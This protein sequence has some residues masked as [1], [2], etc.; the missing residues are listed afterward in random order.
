MHPQRFVRRLRHL[1][2]CSHVTLCVLSPVPALAVDPARALSQ[3]RYQSWTSEHGLPADT[4]NASVHARDGYLWLGTEE[5]LARFD[6]LRFTVF[7]SRN[8][9][10]M[11]D[12]RVRA[13]HEDS[14]GTLWV[15]TRGGGL[16]R[17]RDHSF[18]AITT[19]DGLTSDRILAVAGGP[20][21]VV[22]IATDGGGINRYEN[23]RVTAYSTRQGLSSDTV[24]ALAVDGHGVVWA[25]T[26]AGGLDRLAGSRFEHVAARGQSGSTAAIVPS[27]DG[28]IWFGSRT[29]GLWRLQSGQVAV[30]GG[31]DGLAGDRIMSLL[32]DR[33]ANIWVGTDGHGIVRLRNGNGTRYTAADGF[34]GDIAA[35]LSEDREGSIWIGTGG[36]GLVQ[37]RDSRFVSFGRTEGLSH[38]MALAVLA[39]RSGTI[40]IG[41]HGG[42][43]NRLTAGRLSPAGPPALGTAVIYSLLEDSRGDI[44]VGTADAGIVQ[45]RREGA[46]TFHR[47]GSGLASNT[48]HALLEDDRGV[49]WAGTRG[50]VSRFENGRWTTVT[51]AGG[52]ANAFVTALALGRGGV[53]W[54][55][56]NGGGLSRIDGDRIAT[57]TAE[58]HLANRVRAVHEDSN[59]RVWVGTGGGGLNLFRDGRFL[60]LTSANGVPD[61]IRAIVDDGS[62][63]FWMSSNRGV[64]RAARSQLL[65]AA[66]DPDARVDAAQFGVADGMRSAEI[67]GGFQP[68]AARGTDGRIWFPTAR[69]VTAVDP[70]WTPSPA[71]P[72]QVQIESVSL[73]RTPVTPSDPAAR[74][75]GSGELEVTYTGLWFR[76]PSRLRFQY[77][78]QNFDRGWIDAGTRR[79]AFYTNL[80]AGSYTFRVRTVTA[81]DVWSEADATFAVQLQPRFYQT[82]LFVTLCVFGVA[83]ALMGAYR[84]RLR[85]LR[86]LQADLMRLVRERT[87]QLEEAN[88]SLAQM[89]YVDALTE[90]AN[91]RSFEEALTTE[92]RR[93]AR[94]RSNLSLVMIDIDGFKSYNDALG[95]QAGDECLRKV[96]QVITE[97]AG[98]AA[99]TVARYGGEEFVIL[100]PDTDVAGAAALGERVRAAIDHRNIWHPAMPKDRLTVSVGV[101]TVTG[102]DGQDAAALVRAADNALY[103]AKRDGRNLVRVARRDGV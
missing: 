4:V 56:T 11:T 90:V 17:Y 73:N 51:G 95:H 89:S 64:F 68:A 66:G 80:P 13:L 91:R 14:Q 37:A 70:A 40:W 22:W 49:I 12:H 58:D 30:I 26:A 38:E 47:M 93:A 46:A 101:A 21:G 78:L 61:D 32:E 5:G 71:P 48:I 10:A 54:A 2:V 27:R 97:S 24:S 3:Y 29:G 85:V 99:D 69:G 31:V 96:A 33:D 79:T 76:D 50:G 41:T 75:A 84:W 6:G 74:A 20:G 98:R 1:L 34:A 86:D 35:S 19:R 57:Y 82:G 39:D 9:P 44:W 25:G 15:G 103:Q 60:P 16:V 53:L 52:L 23:G 92:W 7:T 100:L 62:G 55:G 102:Q 45:L 42:G 72:P 43:L 63:A 18:S 77:Q 36:A 65:A 28:S 94:A 8:T 81:E 83:L 67:N 59:G 88:R 87:E